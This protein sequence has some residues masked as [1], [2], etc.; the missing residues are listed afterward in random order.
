MF[1]LNQHALPLTADLREFGESTMTKRERVAKAI[2]QATDLWVQ[3]STTGSLYDVQADAAIAA[4]AEPEPTLRD[5]LI[6]IMGSMPY[7]THTQRVDAILKKL[8]EN[9]EETLGMWTQFSHE[10]RWIH[11]REDTIDAL[12]PKSGA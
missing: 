8:R 11:S 2:A 7:A 9:A 12:I 5:E 10:E 6:E 4:M 1:I 3:G